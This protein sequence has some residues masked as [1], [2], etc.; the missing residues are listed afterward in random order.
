M[1]RFLWNQRMAWRIQPRQTSDRH[2][3]VPFAN[4]NVLGIKVLRQRHGIF[5]ADSPRCRELR[6][7]GSTLPAQELAAAQRCLAEPSAAINSPSATRIRTPSS[8]PSRANLPVVLGFCF[9][10]FAN[11]LQGRGTNRIGNGAGEGRLPVDALSAPSA[12]PKLPVIC[13]SCRDSTSLPN[14]AS[15]ST[16]GDRRAGFATVGRGIVRRG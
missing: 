8:T 16:A 6:D 2:A 14:T 10:S 1:A 9:S 13:T 3:Q 7:R 11:S 12:D 4:C 5:P 15:N